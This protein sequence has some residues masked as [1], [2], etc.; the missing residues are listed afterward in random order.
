[1]SSYIIL[2]TINPDLVGGT[3]TLPKITGTVE[4]SSI[5]YIT[6]NEADSAQAFAAG[7]SGFVNLGYQDFSAVECPGSVTSLALDPVLQLQD[8]GANQQVGATVVQNNG[9]NGANRKI[10]ILD[11]GYN[12]NHPELSS[13]YGGG[14]DF[15][16]NDADPMDD[17]S[18]GVGSPGHGSHVAGIITADGIDGRSKGV[19]PQTKIIAGKVLNSQ[20][21]GQFSSIVTAIYWAVNG[22]DNVFGTTDDFHP[23]AINLS[24]GGGAY[25]NFCDNNDAT[26][27]AMA[28]A[29]QYARSHGTIVVVSAG[30]NSSGVSMPGCIDSSFTVGAVDSNNT[31]AGFSG[32]GNGVDI[33]APGVNIYSSLLGS[34]Y[35]IK[36]GT[37]MATP[38]VSGIIALIKSAFP[39]YT[40]NQVENAI[41]TTA[42]D[43][44]VPG[45]DTLY[46]WGR[47]N[48][49][50]AGTGSTA[51]TGACGTL[52]ASPAS[53]TKGVTTS[54]PNCNITL[55]YTSSGVSPSSLVI[56]RGGTNLQTLTTANGNVTDNNLNAGAYIYSLQNN[57]TGSTLSS[58]TVYVYNTGALTSPWLSCILGSNATNPNCN[59]TLSYILSSGITGNVSIYKDGAFWKSAPAPS[60]T[61]TDNNP[62]VG[63]HTYTLRDNSGSTQT[64]R[65]VINVAS[66]AL[67]PRVITS[68]SPTSARIGNQI[69]ITGANL[70]NE[71]EVAR[72]YLT[73][74]IHDQ[75]RR[76]STTIGVLND[77]NTQG[78]WKVDTSLRPG[79]YTLRVGPDL[80]PNNISNEVNLTI[81]P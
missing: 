69:T 12:Y 59:I 14:K 53:C 68:I 77:A 17:H 78:T 1:M 60:G 31:V 67:K 22:P 21:Q 48:A 63:I 15:I 73:V 54:N 62:A 57:S 24:V 4:A 28:Q 19:A 3:L 81:L 49:S 44:G 5:R 52:V 39:N 34:N 46:G 10:V 56:K 42:T 2:Y 8:T 41:T 71:L 55:S 70:G 6:N 16:N 9:N 65:V 40:V 32:R 38:I 66:S 79:N 50:A 43:L 47:I 29:I 58:I 11:T 80:V 76:R 72:H 30:N 64:S 74:Q 18:G 45:K 61:I 35:G 36:S 13:S 37:S 25:A 20:G 51:C 75:D 23:D 33:T 27:Q 26:S 7:C